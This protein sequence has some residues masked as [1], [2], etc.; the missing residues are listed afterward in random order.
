MQPS[1]VE[2]L[3]QYSLQIEHFE[4]T[5]AILAQHPISA[6]AYRLA[7]GNAFLARD[8][9]QIDA[10]TQ[11]SGLAMIASDPELKGLLR[12]FMVQ[13]KPLPQTLLSTYPPLPPESG[14]DNISTALTLHINRLQQVLESASEQEIGVFAEDKTAWLR[15]LDT[16]LPLQQAI[17]ES[18][19][20][21]LID[22]LDIEP[23]SYQEFLSSPAEERIARV[24]RFHQQFFERSVT[25]TGVMGKTLVRQ[26][27]L[28]SEAWMKAQ[29]CLKTMKSRLL[30]L[31]VVL[32]VPDPIHDT[33]GYG[34]WLKE[35]ITNC[36]AIE[37]ALSQISDPREKEML[38][39]E[40]L[41]SQ[42]N[43][44]S[45]MQHALTRLFHRLTDQVPRPM[46]QQI[47]LTE[48]DRYHR[49]IIDE[50]LQA[51]PEVVMSQDVHQLASVVNPLSIFTPHRVELDAFPTEDPDEV[52]GEYLMRFDMEQF[53][54]H[55]TSY[56]RT[57]QVLQEFAKSYD[58]FFPT[59]LSEE[60][61]ARIEQ[62]VWQKFLADCEELNRLEVLGDEAACAPL[63]ASLGPEVTARLQAYRSSAS[64]ELL[65]DILRREFQAKVDGLVH[66]EKEVALF[67]LKI[68]TYPYQEGRV[69]PEA[70]KK[71]LQQLGIIVILDLPP[72]LHTALTAAPA[73]AP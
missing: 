44:A 38:V 19:I 55:L 28:F 36:C 60:E 52:I 21:R 64:P 3:F 16:F 58:E 56:I 2:R 9:A 46:V 48:L 18:A 20:K 54:S 26:Y 22:A 31:E 71:Y 10:L 57:P 45:H 40:I 35:V 1:T 62:E 23:C 33:E 53:L 11:P 42:E 25:P 66:E 27:A 51:R 49:R 8:R 73:A 32:G 50:M 17:Q 13:L 70:L 65:S 43:C 41:Q 4:M 5:A 63:R 69:K 14:M 59:Q 7:I 24:C 12:R 29:Q 68:A 30:H 15:S 6:A 37:K 72:E 61:N 47:I 67:E 39:L 34:R